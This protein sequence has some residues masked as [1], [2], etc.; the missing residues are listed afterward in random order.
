MR[1]FLMYKDKDLD[2]EQKMPV[3]S[4]DLIKDLELETLFSAMALGNKELYE[5]A[6][7][8]FLTSLD[9]IRTIK[10]RQ[11]ILRD[12]IRNP[13]IIRSIY[14]ITVQT[15]EVKRTHHL[16]GVFSNYP[17]SILYSAV[18]LMQLFVDMLKKIR[19][20]ADENENNFK[21]EGFTAF[22][23]ML[24]T[25][26][27]NEYFSVVRNHL[28]ELTFGHGVLI[29]A[30]LT[31][32]NVSDNYIL[33][34]HL[35]KKGNL[36]KRVFS[37]RLPSYTFFIDPRDES[38][39][40]AISEIENRGINIAA[41]ALAQSTEHI[42]SFF[43]NLRL[44]LS[45]YIGCLNLYQKITDIGLP[46]SFPDPADSTNIKLSYKGLY[47]ICLALTVNKSIVGNDIFA[48]KKTLV[49]ITGANQG[50]KSTFLRSVGL[51]Q[52]MMQCGLFAPA[53]YFSS[54]ICKTL[55][56][57]YR[58]KED[59]SMKSG[60]LDEEL[61]RMSDIL[62]NITPGSIILF[63]ESFSATNEREGSEIAR[64]IVS[65]LLKKNIRIFFVTH[66]YELAGEFYKKR[67]K[68]AIFLIA[69]RQSDGK[70]TFRI[71][72]GK[73]LKTSFGKD[74]YKKIITKSSR[75]K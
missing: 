34:K 3:N 55:F 65:A 72:E 57:H 13:N 47:D 50:G 62:D 73:P 68:N 54:N 27:S 39:A 56:T 11:D 1:V 26:F 59:A 45:F 21:S 19:D 40:K 32:G 70:R 36:V 61:S 63:N 64:Q 74:L 25:E 10:Y 31:D 67:F 41:N 9:D 5:I 75:S 52:L 43:T 48:D 60:K 2:P 35:D 18:Q 24:K 23:K 69:E 38:G 49:I 66:M 4:E 42:Y 30:E 20:I 46:V 44:E 22:F 37:K 71:I 33:R 6:N 8:V 16:G 12:C 29:S 7:K 51:S 53:E 15:I 28:K 58:R 14:D 17:S